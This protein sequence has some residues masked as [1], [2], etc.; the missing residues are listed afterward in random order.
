MSESDNK[1]EQEVVSKEAYT[2][3]SQD[4]HK[5]K[6]QYKQLE[7]KLAELQAEQEAREK[8]AL[9]EKEQWH[10]LYKKAEEKLKN[11]ESERQQERSKFVESHKQNAI[12][13]SL[14]GFKKPEYNKFI[15]TSRITVLEDGSIDESSIQSEV[16]RLKKE[17][18]E[19]I[20]SNSV[21]PLPDSAP[22]G[23][24]PKPLEQMSPAERN[25]LRRQLIRGN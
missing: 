22:K 8:A 19:L 13:Q 4:M 23:N 5:F 14:G 17:Y 15:D 2:K 18:P 21:K 10:L 9:E 11:L 6:S 12:I 1:E 20:K 25:A 24:P 7:S 16:E 3:V